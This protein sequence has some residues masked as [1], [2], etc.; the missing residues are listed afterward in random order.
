MPPLKVTPFDATLFPLIS[1]TG[2]PAKSGSV[3]PSMMTGVA[4]AGSDDA[5]VIV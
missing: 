5:S 1:M 3:V 4:V 2:V